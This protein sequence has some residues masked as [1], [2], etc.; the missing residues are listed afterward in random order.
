MY[1][2]GTAGPGR[3]NFLS[4]PKYKNLGQACIF[5]GFDLVT[6]PACSSAGGKSAQVTVVTALRTHVPLRMPDS[7]SSPVPSQEVDRE[8]SE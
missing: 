8:I 6:L 1:V 2:E 3:F 4:L 7:L 5:L